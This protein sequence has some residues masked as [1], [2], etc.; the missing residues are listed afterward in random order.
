MTRSSF[1]DIA[2]FLPGKLWIAP[3]SARD[4][5]TLSAFHYR[6]CRPATFAG[7]WAVRYA[8]P[9]VPR[10]QAR[11]VAV[12]VLSWPVPSCF[13]RERFLGRFGKFAR[14][15]NLRFAN[16]HVRTISRVIVH[17]QFRSLGLGVTL[18]RWICRHCNTRYVEALATMGR[19]H[20][21]FERAGMT[22]VEPDRPDRP[23]YY[24]F[25]R[26]NALQGHRVHRG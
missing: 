18:V 16:R 1:H 11:P 25:D 23:M 4:Y 10:D 21:L 9:G 13:A 5:A 2:H 6:S 26:R 7:A 22:R 17:P 3:G 8:S 24:I 19:A 14:S 20:P 12:A 15:E